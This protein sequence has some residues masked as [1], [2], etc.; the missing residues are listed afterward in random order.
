MFC[1]LSRYLFLN[2]VLIAHLIWNCPVIEGSKSKIEDEYSD[3]P[4]KQFHCCAKHQKKVGVGHGISGEIMTIDAGLCRK[5]CPRHNTDDPGDPSRPAVQRCPPHSQ[6]HPRSARMERISTLQGVKII[7]TVDTCDC[8][9]ESGCTRVSFEQLIHSGTPYQVAM[10]IGRCL[11][12]CS[13]SLTCKPLKNSTVSIK[14]PN[15]DEIYQI[16]D[17]CGCANNC[18]RMDRTESVLDYSQLEIKPGINTSDVKP[19]IRHIN[20]G[21]CVGSC[22]GNETETCLL[23]DKKEPTR[24]LAALYS[25]HHNCTPA[26][27]KVHE[28]RT[29]RG[30]KREIIQIVE[31]ACIS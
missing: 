3:S 13:K 26:R 15:G 17:K 29:R 20:V 21:Q 2:S 5:V 12:L 18:H 8:W 10:D 28:Y 1:L 9:Q 27:F 7:E 31:C 25:K 4:N 6:C 30:S 16:I 14:G 24:C 22:P 19:V 23:R 11:G